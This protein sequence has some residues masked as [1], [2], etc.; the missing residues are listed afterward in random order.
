MVYPHTQRLGDSFPE[1]FQ[2]KYEMVRY[3]FTNRT[4]RG[5]NIVGNDLIPSEP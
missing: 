1:I 4:L 3:A 5:K 2:P